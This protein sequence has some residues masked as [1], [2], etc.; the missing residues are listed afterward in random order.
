MEG[1]AWQDDSFFCFNKEE[2]ATLQCEIIVDSGAFDNE[3]NE[4]Y[5]IMTKTNRKYTLMHTLTVPCISEE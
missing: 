5:V 1:T 4:P 2:G 3:C